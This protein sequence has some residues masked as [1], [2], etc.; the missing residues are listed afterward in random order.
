MVNYKFLTHGETSP[1]FN[2]ASE[3]YLL[4]QTD[5][6]YFYLWRNAPAVI[7]GVNQ[8]AFE[9]VNLDYVTKNNVSVI[10]RLTGGGAVYHDLNNICYTVI[11]P[12]NKDKNSFRDFCAPVIE[13][14]KTLGLNAEFSGRNDI[15]VDGK[16]IS[17][18]AQ[19]VY[20]GR[21]MHHGTILF[22]TDLD[23]V[24]N[25]LNPNKFKMQSKGIKSVRSRVENV[26]NLLP[27]KM[28][29]DQFFEGLKKAFSKG[30]KQIE[31]SKSDLDAINKLVVEKYSTFEWNMGRSSKGNLRLSNKF[32]FGV[33]TLDADMQKGV[34]ENP[35][36]TGDFFSK[37]P[38]HEF[39]NKLVGLPFDKDSL[40]SVFATLDE[41]IDGADGIKV[42]QELIK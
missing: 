4:K 10:R 20:N 28:T 27:Q 42:L 39:A 15:I 22:E 3:E 23:A 5:G 9:E 36:I 34:I 30:L 38:I 32:D 2:I 25:A 41:Y 16:K 17:G 6:Y 24:T 31:F 1:Q 12:Y 13:Y 11:A 8:N 7:V 40:N 35:V 37:K 19:T 18:N 33:F 21:V 29:I 14:L 26:C